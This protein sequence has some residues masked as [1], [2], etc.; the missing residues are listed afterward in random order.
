MDSAKG[1]APVSAGVLADT[2]LC[3]AFMNE[4]VFLI[5]ELVA[6][7]PEVAIGFVGWAGSAWFVFSKYAEAAE[8]HAERIERARLDGWETDQIALLIT[9]LLRDPMRKLL[10]ESAEALIAGKP[11]PVESAA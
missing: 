11:L 2:E 10:R 4:A 9:G 1:I 5:D 3:S 8:M 6:E 7:R